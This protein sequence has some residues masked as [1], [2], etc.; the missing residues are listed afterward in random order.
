MKE[1]YKF[2]CAVYLLLIKE[3]KIL[4]LKRANTGYEDGNYSLVAGHMDGNETI[5]QAMIREAKEEAGIT[6]AEEDIEIVT[7]LHRKTAPERLDFFLKCDKW[8]G[9]I[10]NKEPYKCSELNWYDINN[11]PS[12]II[13][14][15]KKAI[16]N[17]QNNIMFD[18][19]G[20]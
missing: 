1:R 10:I 3:N 18:N 13:P 19:F 11:L 8:N 4:L 12:N 15:V 2:I 9:E 16:E 5:K 7:F 20:W 6:I 14:C 17:Y